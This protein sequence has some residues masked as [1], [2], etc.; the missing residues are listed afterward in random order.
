MRRAPGTFAITARDCALPGSTVAYNRDSP[1]RVKQ[2]I[3]TA[4]P[5]SP[6]M[7]LPH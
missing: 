3:A 6:A 5:A 7:P 2:S 1:A 4:V